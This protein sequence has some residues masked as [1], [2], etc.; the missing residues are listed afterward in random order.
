[1]RYHH[2]GE[3]GYDRSERVIRQL[4]AEAGHPPAAAMA[5][6]EGRG[7]SAQADAS[8]LRSPETYIG[9][10]RAANF[11][12]PGGQARDA[13]RSYTVPP[14]LELNQWALGGRWTVGRQQAQGA[15]GSRIVFRFHAR[16]LHLVLGSG[17]GRSVRFRI[18]ID[19]RPPGADAGMD[20]DAAGNG[21]VTGERLYQLV[22]QRGAIRDRTFETTFLDPGVRA[23]SFTFG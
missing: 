11:A 22:R 15:A 7:V 16:D 13:E 5:E 17:A 18:A 6:V 10:A 4:L 9:Y 19:G 8:A 20:V 14:A 3:G 12:S 1:V 21:T 2:F 23:F